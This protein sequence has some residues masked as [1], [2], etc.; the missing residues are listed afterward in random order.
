MPG[1]DVFWALALILAGAAGGALLGY[2][3]ARRRLPHSPVATASIQAVVEPAPAPATPSSSSSSPDGF[4]DLVAGLIGA[5]DLATGSPAVRAHLER[6][7]RQ[8]GVSR[9]DAEPGTVFDPSEHSAVDTQAIDAQA[10][11]DLD[12]IARQV[13]PG[14]RGTDVLVRPVEV[15]VWRR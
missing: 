14:W 15:V 13:R 11:A 6:V 10:V 4:D 1:D 2:L 5:H 8:A 7:L 9:V 12:K 3:A